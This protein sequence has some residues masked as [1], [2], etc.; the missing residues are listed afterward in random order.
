[1]STVQHRHLSNTLACNLLACRLREKSRTGQTS[2]EGCGID[3]ID[4]SLIQRNVDTDRA[5]SIAQ[6]RHGKQHGTSSQC[7]LHLFIVPDIIDRACRRHGPTRALQCLCMLT[8]GRS[9]ISGRFR[10]RL[11]CREAS[12]YIRKPHSECAVGIL[13]HDR[14]ILSDPTQTLSPSSKVLPVRPG[15]RG[16]SPSRHLVN[17]SYQPDRQIPARMRDG[18]ERLA[19]RMLERMVIAAHAIEN[20]TIPFQH[21]DQLTAV[22]FHSAHLI[23]DDQK[24]G[25]EIHARSRRAIALPFH[26]RIKSLRRSCVYKYA[27]N[28]WQVP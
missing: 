18:D 9:S 8:Q 14:N 7:R 21:P 28:F 10:Q 6:Q 22:S 12:F 16:S 27:K 1:M 13:L 26:R 23:E 3:L 20:P 15:Q 11:A 17:V 24:L 5:A 19:I 4:K 25:R 2:S